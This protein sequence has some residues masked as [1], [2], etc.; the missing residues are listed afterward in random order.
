M[1]DPVYKVFDENPEAYDSWYDSEE[2]MPLYES[3]LL[4]LRPL[5]SG[6]VRPWLEVGAGTGR[7]AVELGT[8]YASDPAGAALGISVQRGVPGVIAWGQELPFESGSMGAV[9]I[10]YTLPFAG[11]R[12][13][14]VR[15]AFRVIF[16]GGHL[17]LGV[18][19]LESEWGK[20]YSGKAAK[21]DSFFAGAFFSPLNDVLE[22]SSN[23]GLSLEK[24]R[25]TLYSSPLESRF[26]VEQSTDG[27]DPRAGFVALRLVKNP[28]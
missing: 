22:T 14:L 1:E 20:Y 17:I 16:P 13:G 26:E 11:D 8:D 19:P 21:N 25:S 10:I 2:G 5:L 9:F 15:E 6:L 18:V 4:C 7:F 28:K 23:A 12:D 27:A 24:S 3:E